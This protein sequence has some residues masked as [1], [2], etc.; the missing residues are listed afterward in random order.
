MQQ[1]NF[2]NDERFRMDD[3]FLDEND[4]EH[5]VDELEDETTK[6]LAI[7][8]EVLGQPIRRNDPVKKK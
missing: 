3:Q 4:S 6:E 7:L 8:S 2:C 1:N 5:S